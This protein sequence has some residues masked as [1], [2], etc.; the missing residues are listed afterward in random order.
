VKIDF[1]PGGVILVSQ[2][3]ASLMLCLYDSGKHHGEPL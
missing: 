1:T 2:F 3:M